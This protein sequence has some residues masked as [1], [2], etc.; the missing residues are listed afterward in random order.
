MKELAKNNIDFIVS[1]LDMA[2]VAC[3]FLLL[4]MF[5]CCVM[6]VHGMEKTSICT[7]LSP[8][9]YAK[10]LYDFVVNKLQS[11]GLRY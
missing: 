2:C 11:K 10:F 7:T 4:L 1:L 5:I 9:H 6:Y 3:N 8:F